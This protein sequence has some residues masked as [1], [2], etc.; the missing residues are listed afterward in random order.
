MEEIVINNGFGTHDD[1]ISNILVDKDAQE[2]EYSLLLIGA[3]QG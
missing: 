1:I 2:E 3:L